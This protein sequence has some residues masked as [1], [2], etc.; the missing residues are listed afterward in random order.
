MSDPTLSQPGGLGQAFG[1][2]ATDRLAGRLPRHPAQ[3]SA[4]SPPASTPEPRRDQP[5]GPSADKRAPLPAADGDTYPVGVYLLPAAIAAATRHR[6]TRGGDNASLAFDA[7]D[8]MRDRLA[9]LVAARQVGP[10]RPA[11]SLFPARRGESSQA[12]AARTGRRRL[13]AF[14]ATAAE[15]AVIDSLAE[16]VGARSR[17]VLISCAVEEYLTRPRGRAR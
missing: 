3:P 13:W 10:A 17:S 7:L 9:D 2:P 16:S 4:P 1:A 8:T 15:L 6:R 5:A 12:T 14:Q 11:D